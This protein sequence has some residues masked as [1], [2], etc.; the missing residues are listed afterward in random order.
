[1]S[2]DEEINLL[3]WTVKKA[4][5]HRHSDKAASLAELGIVTVWDLLTHLPREYEDR[6]RI[7]PVRDA[8]DGQHATFEGYIDG[9]SHGNHR[10]DGQWRQAQSTTLYE[11]ERELRSYRNGLRIIWFGQ[12]HLASTMRRYDRLRVHGTV[13]IDPSD[14]YPQL[15]QPEYDALTDRGQLKPAVNTGEIIPVYH[16]TRGIRQEYLRELVWTTLKRRQS[17][18]SGGPTNAR[19]RPG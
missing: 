14:E 6:R 19:R 9:V 13:H 4:H 12:Q 15:Y 17:P 3:D 16:L 11:T 10:V 8:R 7:M 1:M 5:P 2:I 18:A